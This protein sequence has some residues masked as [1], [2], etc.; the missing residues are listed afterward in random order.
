MDV[1]E[2]MRSPRCAPL[3]FG[4]RGGGPV[5]VTGLEQLLL[6][7]SRM[8]GDLP[9]LAEMDFNPVLARADSV[10]VVDARVRLGPARTVDPHLRRLR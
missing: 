6:R 2:L 10:L 8:A 5:D 4:H 9:E 7:L 3:V 1:W